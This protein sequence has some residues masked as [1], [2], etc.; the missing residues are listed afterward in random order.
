MGNILQFTTTKKKEKIVFTYKLVIDHFFV[1]KFRPKW[2]QT[3]EPRA[4]K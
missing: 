3:I 1:R 2:I 4:A